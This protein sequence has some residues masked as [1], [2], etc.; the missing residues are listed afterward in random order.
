MIL[1]VNGKKFEITMFEAQEALER[2]ELSAGIS[3]K[4]TSPTVELLELVS[5]WASKRFS[6][7]FTVTAAWQLWWAI[8]ESIESTR[9]SN[10]RIADVGAWLHIDATRLTDDELFG[11]SVNLPRIKA[12]HQ[13]QSGQ[14]DPLKF[15]AIYELTLLATGNESEAREARI[16]AMERYVDSRC[17]GS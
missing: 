13:L 6:V 11:L 10:T 12:Q 5:T 1:R 4:S 9:K 3:A 14:F 7:Q 15:D 17:G 2:C 8:C 16:A